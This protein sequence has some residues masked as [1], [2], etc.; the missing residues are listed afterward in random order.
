MEVLNEIAATEAGLKSPASVPFFEAAIAEAAGDALVGI[1]RDE[2][3]AKRRT[4]ELFKQ[5]RDLVPA[6]TLPEYIH[7][8]DLADVIRELD[9]DGYGNI[10]AQETYRAII[11]DHCEKYK[12]ACRSVFAQEEIIQEEVVSRTKAIKDE[13]EEK[14]YQDRKRSAAMM[15]ALMRSMPLVLLIPVLGAVLPELWKPFQTLPLL[16]V[17]W[18][19]WKSIRA[20]RKAMK[21]LENEQN[22]RIINR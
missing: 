15:L 17:V 4:K 2:D 16:G 22:R 9:K 13:L 14:N 18:L 7:Q 19:N 11:A 10:K 12:S 5:A 20:V 6:G 3:W 8:E 1:D 21:D